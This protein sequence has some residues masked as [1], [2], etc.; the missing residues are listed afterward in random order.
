V[1]RIALAEVRAGVKYPTIRENNVNRITEESPLYID[2]TDPNQNSNR[3][4]LRPYDSRSLYRQ[5]L[6]SL[7]LGINVRRPPHINMARWTNRQS[8]HYRAQIDINVPY[9]RS[10]AVDEERFQAVVITEQMRDAAWRYG[11]GSQMILDGTFGVSTESILCFILMVV[12]EDYR[13]IPVG[14]LLFSALPHHLAV[15]GSYDTDIMTTMLREWKRGIERDRPGEFIPHSCLTDNDSK[16]RGALLRV[17]EDITLLLCRYHLRQSW[18]NARRDKFPKRLKGEAARNPVIM[19][20]VADIKGRITILERSSLNAPDYETAN[21]LLEAE[22]GYLGGMRV[23]QQLQREIIAMANGAYNYVVYLR[24]HWVTQALFYAWAETGR[25]Q[26]A[27]ALGVPLGN[28]VNTSNHLESFN[29]VLKNGWLRRCQAGPRRLRTDVLLALLITRIIPGIFRTRAVAQRQ[30]TWLA[31]LLDGMLEGQEG[32]GGQ[33]RRQR[34]RERR[35]L[36]RVGL[37][38]MLAWL[39][40]AEDPNNPRQVAGQDVF[41]RGRVQ[42]IF[43][44]HDFSRINALCIPEFQPNRLPLLPKSDYRMTMQYERTSGTWS[45]ECE[46]P[47]F[48]KKG[49]ACKH[50]RAFQMAINS[51][52]N[53]PS[54]L[55]LITFPESE[56]QAAQVDTLL[57]G[58][59]T[60]VPTYSI[61]SQ[62]MLPK[63]YKTRELDSLL[64]LGEHLLA[65]DVPADQ[66]LTTQADE[67]GQAMDVDEASDDEDEECE[68]ESL[69]RKGL[70]EQVTSHVIHHLEKAV[71]AVQEVIALQTDTHIAC[72]TDDVRKMVNSLVALSLEVVNKASGDA[73]TLSSTPFQP[74][75]TMS[76]APAIPTAPPASGTS[77]YTGDIDIALTQGMQAG[78]TATSTSRDMRGKKSRREAD[79]HEEEED[80]IPIQKQSKQRRKT[81]KSRL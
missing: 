24:S 73:S 57:K 39:D 19:N 23:D 12:D 32:N 81:S 72:V 43:I 71:T 9:F 37:A 33:D 20:A 25:L 18:G 15:H 75:I 79:V 45:A 13:G 42:H 5:Y 6:D 41:A 50:L 60:D 26:L 40:P 61:N 14:F 64:E 47:D 55:P 22:L 54:K 1:Y 66:A 16:E 28:I 78:V 27:N 59:P 7:Q 80:L 30:R 8:P 17:W 56:K 74:S 48:R 65:D 63:E 44:A 49:G 31:R 67:N 68:K 3:Y 77:L 58:C 62:P 21:A 36:V 11:H 4:E 69:A 2:L 76:L 52:A 29:N 53:R 70:E 35:A 34:D 10:H 46:C 38:R 51:A